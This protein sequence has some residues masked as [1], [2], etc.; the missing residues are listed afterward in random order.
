MM[1]VE[2]YSRCAD[3]IDAWAATQRDAGKLSEN[4]IKRM[5]GRMHDELDILYW[6]CQR[7][8]P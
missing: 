2:E 3:L 5:T 7:P 4:E 1:T 6:F 8:V